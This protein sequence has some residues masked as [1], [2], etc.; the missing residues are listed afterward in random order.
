MIEKGLPGYGVWRRVPGFWPVL[1]SDRGF[2]MTMG[3]KRVRKQWQRETFYMSVRCNER[4][5]QVHNLVCRAFH[6]PALPHHASVDHMGDKTLPMSVRRANN[7][8][9]NL[10]WATYKQQR[11]NQR[12]HKSK[13]T[14]Q[15]CI[16]W[17]VKGGKRNTGY[18]ERI[19]PE[20]FF[21][22]LRD[23]ATKLKVNNLRLSNVFNS[24]TKTVCNK[25]GERFAGC[26]NY[27]N[28]D[29]SD[30]QWLHWSATLKISN[31]G[32]VQTKHPNGEKWGPKRFPVKLDGHGY[33]MVNVDGVPTGV[34][35]LVGELFF[36]GP[37]PRNW[38][39]W[40]HKKS[41][42]KTNNHISNIRPVTNEEN[43]TNTLR[44]RPF[45]IWKKTTPDEKILCDNQ[46]DVARTYNIHLGHLNDLLHKRKK[47]NGSIPKSVNGYCAVFC[48]LD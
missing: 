48:E 34:Y 27:D 33:L 4:R 44:K 35:T 26:Y 41:D 29:L 13:S 30:E 45:Y 7:N 5:E 39:K 22:S 21:E 37:R 11:A 25:V 14:G 3:A 6:G 42:Q 17:R 38:T 43:G 16:V 19:G 9:E 18:M 40:D 46:N 2:I 10:R 31:H 1:A 24:S 8:A 20:M 36:I 28:S 12:I 15:P 47:A 32:R 23:A